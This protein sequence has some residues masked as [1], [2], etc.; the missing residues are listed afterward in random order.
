MNNNISNNKMS[1]YGH[2]VE[3]R[4]RL[5]I[6]VAVFFVI[7][8]L[9]LIKFGNPPVSFSDLV[10][11]FLQRPLAALLEERNGRMIFTA[12][13][14]GF[15]TQIKVAFFISIIISLPIILAQIWRFIA[16][17]LYKNEKK[18]LLPFIIATPFLFLLG[19]SIVYY[20]VMPLA[21][22]FFL[23]FEIDSS[24][25]SLPIEI[26]PR[27]SEYLS[28]VMR[29]IIAF[30]LCFQLP[31]ILLLLIKAKFITAEWL[32]K[33]RKYAILIAF[34]FSAILTPPDVIS[35]VML[36]TPIVF[37]YEISILIARVIYKN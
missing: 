25:S 13:H 28:L 17:G 31:V 6:C 34:I 11:I 14:E 21:W 9:C 35:Q 18:A 29:L 1:L 23:S 24:L 32:A 33:R 3:L 4:M 16:P 27:I 2:L 8:F 15:F 30:G 22:E 5:L 10:Y 7:F 36:A 26:E 19:A 37:L 12:L 20:L